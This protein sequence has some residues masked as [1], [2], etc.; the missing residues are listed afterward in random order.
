MLLQER[1]GIWHVSF[2]RDRWDLLQKWDLPAKAAQCPRSLCTQFGLLDQGAGDQPSLWRPKWRLGRSRGRCKHP[3]T[4]E[5]YQDPIK[6]KGKEKI[7]L[8]QKVGKKQTLSIRL[9]KTNYCRKQKQIFISNKYSK[10]WNFGYRNPLLIYY[11]C[12]CGGFFCCCFVSLSNT[13]TPSPPSLNSLAKESRPSL[14]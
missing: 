5:I 9:L 8:S 2:E 4:G 12:V 14:T 11:I 6:R 13:Q 7:F 10:C 1:C 3:I